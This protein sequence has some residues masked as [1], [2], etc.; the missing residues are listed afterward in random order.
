MSGMLTRSGFRN[1]SNTRSN[2][3][4]SMSVIRIAHASQRACRRPAARTHRDPL[5]FD[6][7]MNSATISR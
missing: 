2:R 6:Q 4:G 3:I 1:R 5:S 7:L